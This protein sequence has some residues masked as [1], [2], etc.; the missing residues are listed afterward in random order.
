MIKLKELAE[1]LKANE[2]LIVEETN[3]GILVKDKL[4]EGKIIPTDL[5]NFVKV[6]EREPN[7]TPKGNGYVIDLTEFSGQS[8]M[9][10]LM[11]VFGAEYYF[12]VTG[13]FQVT[14]TPKAKEGVREGLEEV[15]GESEKVDFEKVAEAIDQEDIEIEI[16]EDGLRIECANKTEIAEA[17]DSLYPA[18]NIEITE[19]EIFV[20]EE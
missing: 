5:V 20:T 2:N 9:M 11:S 6:Y 15:K 1:I 8:F 7:I 4:D 3:E 13:P 14:A 16:H 19:K 18:L 10:L 12:K 17:I